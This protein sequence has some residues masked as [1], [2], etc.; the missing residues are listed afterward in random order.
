VL[1]VKSVP[2]LIH[3]FIRVACNWSIGPT[4]AFP[5]IIH[6]A[7]DSDSGRTVVCNV[8]FYVRV[9]AD[10]WE[11]FDIVVCIHTCYIVAYHPDTVRPLF[12]RETDR[13]K[14]VKYG[15]VGVD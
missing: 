2:A 6:S 1:P 13:Y 12:V 11:V 7:I 9:F 3:L 8:C 5:A 14:P 10:F 4:R 15:R